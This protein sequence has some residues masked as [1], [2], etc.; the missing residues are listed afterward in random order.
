MKNK[1]GNNG[2]FIKM[3]LIIVA[4]LVLL[5]YAYDIDVVG[6]LT[7]GRFKELLDQFYALGAKGWT[8]Y[9]DVIIKVWSYV[10]EFIKN[11]ITKI[12]S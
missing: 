6:F 3:T 5:K 8:M 10:L 9:K 2:G 7:Q 1:N 12:K 11:L 4:A